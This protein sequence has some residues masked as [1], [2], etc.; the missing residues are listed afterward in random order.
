MSHYDIH[1][2]LTLNPKQDQLIERLYNKTK[3][4]FNY[5]RS[6][7]LD[8]IIHHPVY[9]EFTDDNRTDYQDLED[10]IYEGIKIFETSL[11]KA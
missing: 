4:D 2:H 8:Y 6:D 10:T 3:D 11:I 5:T 7:V 1:Y 9:Y